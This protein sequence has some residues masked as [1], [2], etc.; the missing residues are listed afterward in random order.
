MNSEIPGSTDPGNNGQLALFG[1]ANGHRAA[2]ATREL[3]HTTRRIYELLFASEK[4]MASGANAD[5][6]ILLGGTRVINR[7]TSTGNIG[8]VIIWMNARFHVSERAANLG[9]L[10]PPRKG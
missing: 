10:R 4:R 9:M 3:L 7:A 6:N 2:I 8:Y 5:F 1:H